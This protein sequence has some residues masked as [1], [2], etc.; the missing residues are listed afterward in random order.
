MGE[1]DEANEMREWVRKNMAADPPSVLR[2]NRERA[3]KFVGVATDGSVAV[4]S[5]DAWRDRDKI[6][7]YYLGKLYVNAAGYADD[8]VVENHELSTHLGIPENTVPARVKEL[9]DGRVIN[10]VGNGRH[11]LP[12]SG[13][14]RILDELEKL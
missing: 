8:A 14:T 6:A 1:E 2:D 12:L 11:V 9:R 13:V 10:S 3:A 5:T 7:A 4:K